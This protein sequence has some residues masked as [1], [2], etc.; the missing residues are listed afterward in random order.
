MDVDFV[1]LRTSWSPSL[2]PALRLSLGL[3]YSYHLLR[4]V[5]LL[6]GVNSQ[7]GGRAMEFTFRVASTHINVT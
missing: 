2:P 6:R 4:G 5:A 1:S 7:R 3:P